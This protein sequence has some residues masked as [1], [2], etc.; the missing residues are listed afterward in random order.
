M[1]QLTFEIVRARL[2]IDSVR[3]RALKQGL[4]YARAYSI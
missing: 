1:K 2:S 3:V 4:V